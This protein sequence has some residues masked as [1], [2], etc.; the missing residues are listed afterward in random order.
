MA[1]IGK[2]AEQEL[3][4]LRVQFD[5][6][7][8]ERDSLRVERDD[9]HAK[10]NALLKQVYGRRSERYVD[11]GHPLLPFDE[12]EDPREVVR[13]I[14]ARASAREGPSAR[15]PGGYYVHPSGRLLALF[16]RSDVS[17]GGNYI[18]EFVELHFD[19]LKP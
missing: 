17:G 8:A 15:F 3:A 1:D 13:R 19:G 18:Y 11:D 14:D 6:V 16:V 7:R 12:P 10:L 5:A 2:S 9:L 4:E